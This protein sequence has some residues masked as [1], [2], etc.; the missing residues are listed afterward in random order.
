MKTAMQELIDEIVEHLT[1][2]DLTD[3]NRTTFE[4]IRLR[5]LSKLTKEKQQII[6]AYAFG[7][8]VGCI[9]MYNGNKEFTNQ[10]EYYNKTY[11][12]NIK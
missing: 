11:N 7:H 1:Y 10:Q 9:Y 2:D 3:D 5:L 6:S 8:N 12:E 4:T